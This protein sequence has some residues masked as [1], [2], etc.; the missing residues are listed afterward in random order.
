MANYRRTATGNWSTLAEW[1]DDSSGSYAASS[2]LPGA[3]DVVYANGFT[4]T[5][6]VDVTV[7]ELRNTTG[8]NVNGGGEFRTGTGCDTVTADI[9][10]GN[11]T[12]AK[13]LT[14]EDKVIIGNIYSGIVTNVVG[15]EQSGN[16]NIIIIGNLYGG[17]GPYARGFRI[18]SAGNATITGNLV[19][20]SGFNAVGIDHNGSGTVTINGNS[21]GGSG[22]NSYGY[23]V[24]GAG[25]I[26]INGTCT[27]GSGT[28]SQGLGMVSSFNNGTALING[29][30]IGGPGTAE[31][32]RIQS[33]GTV[34]V[35]AA[36]S[37]STTAGLACIPSGG[38][39]PTAIVEYIDFGPVGYN[40][41]LGPV[42]FDNTATKTAKIVLENNSTVTLVD[43][44]T[45]SVPSESDVRNGV[46]YASGA[47]TGT[48]K[49]P[50]ASSV[51][52]GVP[53]DNTTGTAMISI[54]DMG[55]LLTSFKIA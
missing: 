15:F 53:V 3:A 31:G 2:T 14:A 55:T 45:L 38:L 47:L 11:A 48:L 22:G 52:V 8:T 50:S 18:T 29:F 16:S 5:L 51:A 23:W 26:I 6:D 40:P 7:L 1:E 21:T 43:P 44:S 13:N 39:N 46:S 12:C 32:V 28:N 27:G 41:T 9:I 19:G 54:T 24:T 33:N 34:R 42:K 35:T 4:T 30:A 36:Q 37:S 20:G 49:V 25:N 10:A 17:A